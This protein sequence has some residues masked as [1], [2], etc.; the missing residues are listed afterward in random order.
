MENV[1]KVP[2]CSEQDSVGSDH[3][4]ADLNMAD[5]S[6]QLPNLEALWITVALSS[7]PCMKVNSKKVNISFCSVHI[8]HSNL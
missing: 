3:Q 1:T 2:L 7:L 5:L 4:T 8:K 6:I